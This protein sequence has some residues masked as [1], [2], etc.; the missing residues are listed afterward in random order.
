M[1]D[2]DLHEMIMEGMIVGIIIMEV[3]R[4]EEFREVVSLEGDPFSETVVLTVVVEVV[5]VA[6]VI[7]H[8]RDCRRV[9]CLVL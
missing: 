6:V 3:E 4:S 9:F 1:A 5:E 7:A 8:C 2:V